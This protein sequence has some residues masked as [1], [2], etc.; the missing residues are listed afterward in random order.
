MSI[1]Q[2][3]FLGAIQGLTEFLPV[4]SSGHLVL[5]QHLMGIREPELLFDTALHFGTLLALLIVFRQ[6]VL[7]L[8]RTFLSLFSPRQLKMLPERYRQDE[9][10][11][12]LVLIVV[13]TIP[14]VALGVAFKD[15]FEQLFSSVGVVG[16]T[17]CITGTLL[18][19]TR[20]FPGGRRDIMQVVLL[21]ALVIGFVQGLAITPG[22][23]RSGS[24]IAIAL[25]L[26]IERETS[27]RFSFLLSLPAVFGATLL[28]FSTT[29]VPDHQVSAIVLGTLAA[30]ITGYVSLVFLLKLIKR[31]K[32][33]LFAPY[34]FLA[35]GVAL[36]CAFL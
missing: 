32:F 3:I 8:L 15:L 27:G 30:L 26:G 24:T 17:L 14:T 31:G 5:F 33:Y 6:D 1:W 21:Q 7:H 16:F 12:L 29:M 36:V 13:G 20:K 9:N 18:L 19:F 23:S 34:C 10:V 4:S 28:N 25:F 2:A 35:G 11:R 22:I